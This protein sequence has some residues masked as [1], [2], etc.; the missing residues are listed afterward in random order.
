MSL[1]FKHLFRSIKRKPLQPFI[2][3]LTLL[4]SVFMVTSALSLKSLLAEETALSFDAQ[5]G[6]A[7]VAVSLNGNST[8]RFMFK[9]DA[10]A[11]LG[12]GCR[13]VG[14]YEIVMA[15]IGST[16][17]VFAVAA[18]LSEI[19][20]VFDL[21][22][23]EYGRI[24]ESSVG[25]VMLISRDYA[26]QNGL[27]IGD[28]VT[29]KLLGEVV[30]YT[31]EGISPL[32]YMGKYDVLIDIKGVVDAMSKGSLIA[33]SLGDDFR[34]SGT[35]Y[36]DISDTEMTAEQ[37]IRILQSDKAFAE[38]TFLDIGEYAAG[39]A[40]IKN[41]NVAIDISVVLICALAMAVTFCCFYILADERSEE[42]MSFTIAGA[43]PF[44][45]RLI[46]YAEVV[47]YWLVGTVG[48]I[49]ASFGM[50]DAICDSVGMRYV[51][52]ELSMGA[53]IL[54][55]SIVLLASLATV[56]VFIFTSGKKKARRSVGT[57]PVLALLAVVILWMVL[58]FTAP[59]TVRFVIGIA[60]IG[61]MIL[62]FFV[63]VPCAIRLISRRLSAITDNGCVDGGKSFK[64]LKYAIKNLYSVRQLHNVSRLISTLVAVI[65]LACMLIVGTHNYVELSEKIFTYEH[66]L[67]G[68]T[69]RCEA[70]VSDCDKVERTERVY[71]SA[72]D[73]DNRVSA[74]MISVNNASSLAPE[75]KV[76]ELPSG[77][78]AYVSN[79]VSEALGV[80]LGD[81]IEVNV[82]GSLIALEIGKI[83]NSPLPYICFDC[84]AVGVQPN[85]F[86]VGFNSDVSEAEGLDTVTALISDDVAV[87]SSVSD[88]MAA[89]T[90]TLSV[91]LDCG[92]ILWLMV[93]VFSL[94]GL[95][96]CIYNN[97]RAR[98]EEFALFGLSGMHKGEIARLKLYEIVIAL[99]FGCAA[100]I[101][102][103]LIITPFIR[104]SMLSVGIDFI[105]LFFVR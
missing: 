29:Y 41:L 59:H 47:L 13:I 30:T 80:K 104:K 53:L 9:K 22:F 57:V 32:R 8:S 63:T 19:G 58:I 10:E 51:T 82:G 46:Q 42:N 94:I 3:I 52:P 44:R 50:I 83:E 7:D 14:T 85:L 71:F 4:L 2:M 87:I 21:M 48:G 5:Y 93:L 37:C 105:E 45:L 68:A 98:R 16:A 18:E 43:S 17:P 1:F 69:E 33:S 62:L 28:S 70:K 81:T 60:L 78:V 97:Y 49:L 77:N 26:E 11:L 96:D 102:C 34:P 91:Y 66:V 20:D 95:I 40:N 89:K 74:L 64:C 39:Q 101:L 24:T 92:D 38:K 86:M 79:S 103:S 84:E 54:A 90:Q 15:P 36:I 23:S 56:T 99:I 73:I 75:L 35:L 88:L 25:R 72:V 65:V 12:E 67:I 6:R 31:V 61:F 76:T 55:P 100:G 27:G